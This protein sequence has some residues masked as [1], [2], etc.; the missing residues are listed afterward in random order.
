MLCSRCAALMHAYAPRV[1]AF[2]SEPP[3]EWMAA[4]GYDDAVRF[5]TACEAWKREVRR[6]CHDQSQEKSVSPA[7]RGSTHTSKA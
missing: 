3:S 5:A 2:L 4:M 6:A 7:H 1:R